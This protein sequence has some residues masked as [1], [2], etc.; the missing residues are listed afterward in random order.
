MNNTFQRSIN[1]VIGSCFD[2][3]NN[4]K[5]NTIREETGYFWLVQLNLENTIEDHRNL[6]SGNIPQP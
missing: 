2:A 6:R 3:L 5:G 4:G 1:V